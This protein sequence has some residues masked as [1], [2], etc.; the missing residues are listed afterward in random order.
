MSQKKPFLTAKDFEGYLFI[1]PWI[2]GF[3]LF[4]LGP[5]LFSLMVSFTNWNGVTGFVHS[6]RWVGLYNYKQLL[7]LSLAQGA[8]PARALG[9]VV[10]FSILLANTLLFGATAFAISQTRRKNF[11]AGWPAGFLLFLKAGAGLQAA[12]G[13]T[14]LVLAYR[15]QWHGPVFILLVNLP[16]CLLTAKF[17][18]D[19][20][21]RAR[22]APQAGVQNH[23]L[24]LGLTSL[25]MMVCFWNATWSVYNGVDTYF[26]ISIWNTLYYTIGSVPLGILVGIVLA[27]LL[28]AKIPGISL[29]RTLF[30]SP[31]VIAGVA[32]IMMW[33]WVFKPDYGIFHV[34]IQGFLD[35]TH[36]SRLSL[37]LADSWV[38]GHGFFSSPPSSPRRART[39]TV[40]LPRAGWPAPTGPNR[41]LSSWPGGAWPAAICSFFW[42]ACRVFPITCTRRR[43]LTAPAS[44]SSFSTSPCPCSPPPSFFC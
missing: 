37:H 7:G 40:F 8:D 25:L 13:L 35:L 16:I 24:R 9:N 26:Y 6:A 15:Q 29:F 31:K 3:C 17:T 44:S 27:T 34:I 10:V 33:G 43:K 30:Y 1:A 41:P 36:L 32:T 5:Y 21:L 23:L 39:C 20:F 18:R 14:A 4:Q 42:P 2:L 12:A 19:F 38:E 22:S 11:V 28:N